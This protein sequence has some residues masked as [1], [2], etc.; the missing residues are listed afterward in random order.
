[1]AR[2]KSYVET[3]HANG[4]MEIELSSWKYFHDYIRKEMLE[5]SHYFWRGQRDAAWGLETSLDRL[6]LSKPLARQKILANRL[7]ANF[8][9]S[10]RGRRGSNP[11]RDMSEN[12][13]WALG[14]HNSLAT[15]LLDWTTAPFVALYFAFEKEAAPKSGKRAIWAIYPD[16]KNNS[17]KAKDPS[18]KTPAI[19]EVIRPHQDDNAR[20][21]NQGGLFTR[22]PIGETVTSWVNANCKGDTEAALIKISIPD[23]DRQDCLR[24]LNRMNINHLTLFPDLYGAGQ[25]C[26]KT[27]LI[28]KY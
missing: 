7:L 5:Y 21:V 11:S 14:Q 10:S 25:H 20:L 28:E 8:K 13:W 2:P 3:A 16:R 17:I 26:N 22:A 18:N 4:L 23:V 6:I 15:P 24:S 1:M 27:L 19:L 9:M 12:D